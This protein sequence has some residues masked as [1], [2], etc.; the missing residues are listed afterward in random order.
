MY[1][2]ALRIELLKQGLEVTQQEPINV[3]YDGQVVGSFYADLWV[4]NRVI[5]EV[6]AVQALGK[7]HEVQL[8]NY[9]TATGTDKGL[10]LSF[11]SSSVQIKHKFRQYKPTRSR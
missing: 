7:A 8:V 11:G 4:E 5:V 6:K 10:L 2:N 9:L 1:E 3:H